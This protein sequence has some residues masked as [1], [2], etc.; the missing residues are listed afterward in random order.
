MARANLEAA[1][2][3]VEHVRERYPVAWERAVSRLDIEEGEVDEWRACAAGMTI[4]FDAGLGIHPQDDFFLDREVWDLSRTPAELFPLLLNYHPLVIYRFQVLK[5]ADVVL[6][7]FLQ[8]D[9]FT[10]R[11]EARQRRV[12]RPDHH[13]RLQPVGHR[14]VDHGR[15]GGL[16]RG[17]ARLLPPGAVRRPAR[18]ARQH[19]RRA[20]RRLGRRRVAGARARLRRAARPRRGDV[21]RPA[22]SPTAGGRCGSASPGG[23]STWRSR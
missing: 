20:A 7:M 10:P 19:R 1:V 21:V 13:R 3:A 22:G 23:G 8:G 5:Q 18:P 12:L 2:R 4:P 16:P 14:P 6:A 11:G 9:R 17:G 15:R